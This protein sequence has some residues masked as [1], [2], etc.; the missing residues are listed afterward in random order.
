LRI[1]VVSPFIDR[2]HGTE[3]ALAELI[4]RLA[5]V[6]SC[7]VHLYAQRVADL[8]LTPAGPSG[9]ASRGS[10]SWHRVPVIPGPQLLRF[11]AWF[12]LNRV[13]RWGRKFDLVLSPGINCADADVVIVHALFR[14]LVDLGRA[15]STEEAHPGFLRQLHRRLYYGLLSALERRVYADPGVALAAVSR[16]TAS[17]LDQYFGRK[18]VPVVHNGVDTATFSPQACAARRERVRAQYQFP[19]SDFVLLLIGNDWTTKGIRA[20][21]ESMLLLP[22]L[23]L[24]LLVVGSD[25]REPHVQAATR[26]G[27]SERCTWQPWAADVLDYYAAADAYV[28]PSREDSFSLPV[29][30]AMAC[31]LPAVT[32]TA[33]G[34]CELMTDGVDGFVL[35]DPADANALARILEKLHQNPSLRQSVGAAAAT[36]ARTCTWDRNAAAAWQILSA[37]KSSGRRPA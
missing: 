26:L 2:R 19:S 21:F 11:A 35:Q 1:A 5:S 23:S 22:K 3:R 37:A 20:V 9:Q 30:E 8:V 13:Q 16:H 15:A 6:Y 17:L 36:T 33:A 34:A 24:R 32:S 4:E 10:I 14:R 12:V 27:L 29:L 25:L 18:S 28:C 31:G 7:E